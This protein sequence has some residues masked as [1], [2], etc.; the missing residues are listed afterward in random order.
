[1]LQNIISM[2]NKIKVTCRGEGEAEQ[3][4]P[5]RPLVSPSSGLIVH[6]PKG[7]LGQSEKNCLSTIQI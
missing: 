2:I 5:H 1:M 6:W 3:K 7:L 4:G